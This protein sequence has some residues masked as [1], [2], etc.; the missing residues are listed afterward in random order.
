VGWL[1]DNGIKAGTNSIRARRGAQ[2]C[3]KTPSRHTC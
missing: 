2:R 3:Q 1:A